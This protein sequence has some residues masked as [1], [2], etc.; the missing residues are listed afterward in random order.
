VTDDLIK[1]W[2]LAGLALQ[3]LVA[4]GLWSMRHAFA[5]KGD[6]ATLAK[7][8]GDQ[9]NAIEK[10]QLQHAE[11]FKTVPSAEDLNGVSLKLA[12]LHGDHKALRA[13]MGGVKDAVD[14]IGS[15]VT[16]IENYLLKTGQ[17]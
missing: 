8:L 5:S 16:R 10:E 3:V 6:L 9:V 15:S 17:R 1:Y 12:E 7:A 2:P 13:E 4:W 11:R 14:T